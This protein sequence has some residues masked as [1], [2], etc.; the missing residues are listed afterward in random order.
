[1]FIPFII[2]GLLVLLIMKVV[3]LRFIPFFAIFIGG[4]AA[5]PAVVCLPFFLFAHRW[6]L[7]LAALAFII[8]AYILDRQRK[9]RAAAH[10]V[11]S[12]YHPGR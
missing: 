4:I 8:A 5:L 10:S 6:P 12:G 2:L 1:M 3:F 9:A 11:S 7:L